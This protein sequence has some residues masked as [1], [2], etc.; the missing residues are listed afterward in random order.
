MPVREIQRTDEFYRGLMT[1]RLHLTVHDLDHL[2]NLITLA[3]H[4]AVEIPLHLE[5]DTGL[6]RSGAPREEVDEMLTIIHNHRRLRLT[7]I[8]THFSQ[9]DR[10]ETFTHMQ[11]DMLDAI[12]ERHQDIIGSEVIIHAANTHAMFR[13]AGYHRRMVRVGLGWGGYARAGIS[14]SEG[15][16]S[17][18]GEELIPVV[19]WRSRIMLLKHLPAETPVGYGARWTTTRDTTLGLIPV[20]YAG[21]YPSRVTSFDEE[22]SAAPRVGVMVENGEIRYAPVVGAVSMDQMQIDLTD[23]MRDHPIGIDTVVE[24]LSPDPAAPNSL[25]ALAHAAGKLPYELLCGLSPSIRRHYG[26]DSFLI[27][28]KQTTA[29]PGT[30]APISSPAAVLS[31]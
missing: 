11:M 4:F 3:D 7:G 1:G 12:L 2:H 20:G 29:T 26:T 25:P 23:I 27:E 10:N 15:E 30:Q 8:F 19:R 6:S 21:G 14:N 22:G 24:L 17:Q 28:T 31:S 9:A 13:H 5:I 16:F 18:E